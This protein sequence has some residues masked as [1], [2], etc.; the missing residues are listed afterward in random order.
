MEDRETPG[1]LFAIL[2][3]WDICVKI[4]ANQIAET[5]AGGRFDS[6]GTDRPAAPGG[7]TE[8]QRF[9]SAGR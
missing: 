6:N 9:S 7:F 4:K 8:A 3:S 1:P 5:K 2:K